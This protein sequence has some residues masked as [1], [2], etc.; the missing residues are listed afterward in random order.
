[1]TEIDAHF[2]H[3]EQAHGS[4]TLVLYGM[5]GC[6][7]TQLS[8]SYCRRAQSSATYG[9]VLW[10]D[11]SSLAT[12]KEGFSTAAQEI[13]SL[14][15]ENLDHETSMHAIFKVIE[16]S[17]LP[18]LF[19]FDN[20]DDLTAYNVE[21]FLPKRGLRFII[22]TSRRTESRRLGHSL[23][24]GNLREA[25]AL[26]LLFGKHMTTRSQ[27]A[28]VQGRKVVKRLG[29]LALAIAQ[30][31]AFTMERNMDLEFFL[32][33]YENEQQ[34]IHAS[35][36][37]IWRYERRSSGDDP[38]RLPLSIA[39][40][41][42]LSLNLVSG[43]SFLKSAKAQLLVVSSF[44]GRTNITQGLFNNFIK[45]GVQYPKWMGAF[46]SPE[47]GTLDSYI[48]REAI[49]EMGRLCLLQSYQIDSQGVVWQ[50]HPVVQDWAQ[51]REGQTVR[52]EFA[53]LALNILRYSLSDYR[54]ASTHNSQ[55]TVHAYQSLRPHVEAC[56][57]NCRGL[58]LEES[59]L[60][61]H[62]TADAAQKLANFFSQDGRYELAKSLQ[63]KIVKEALPGSQQH[64]WAL[65]QLANTLTRE[66]ELVEA[67][68]L[69]EQAV[70]SL[71]VGEENVEDAFQL[72]EL[73][74]VYRLEAMVPQLYPNTVK[75]TQS[76][77]ALASRALSAM[78]RLK[79]DNSL[80]VVSAMS[81]LAETE[82]QVGNL[83]KAKAIEEQVLSIRTKILGETNSATLD[84]KDN[85]A[86][87]YAKQKNCEEAARMHEEVRHIRTSTLGALHPHTLRTERWLARAWRMAGYLDKARVLNEDILQ[88]ALGAF[89]H[90][91]YDTKQA[92]NALWRCL[93][94]QGL[95]GQADQIQEEFGLL[96]TV[97]EDAMRAEA[98][99]CQVSREHM[100]VK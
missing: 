21:S 62:R 25:E 55:Y 90:D 67:A 66:Q 33:E 77:L 15:S 12:I 32:S 58:L 52:G 63:R 5:G 98:V 18:W 19:V 17:A 47:T 7:K 94:A 75:L 73:S 40:T 42:E 79:G 28:L 89:G 45:S 54:N 48:F 37:V 39:T 69:H 78:R 34:R 31:S 9:G 96:L 56:Y 64:K 23:Q 24:V 14:S 16:K 60:A 91:H 6:G 100:M 20:M 99:E 82:Y 51:H 29:Y 65:R 86:V 80:E 35:L 1:M 46:T 70:Q 10:I 71:V 97:T 83:A 61:E 4:M 38:A 27:A 68:C 41:F 26:N 59:S 92:A 84:A 30:A 95:I 74:E 57:T 53:M 8:L 22:I 36:P 93:V 88:R 87:T 81:A 85:L 76:S 50:F 11:G 43:D 3:V 2:K 72:L 13:L 49:S 44:F